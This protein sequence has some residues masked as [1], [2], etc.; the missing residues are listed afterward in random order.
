MN[1]YNPTVYIVDDDEA[2][3]DSLSMSLSIEGFTVQEHDCANSFLENYDNQPG[4]LVADI[5]MP[6]MNGLELQQE[7]IK[8]KIDIPIIFITGHGSIP[9][10]VKAMQSG[11]VNFMEKPFSK[12]NLIETI[13]Q[14]LEIDEECRESNKIKYE[15]NKRFDTLTAREKEI[16]EL[17][18]KERGS[19]SNREIA[20]LLGISKRTVEVHRSA[21]M[22]KMLARTRAELVELSR[23]CTTPKY[24]KPREARN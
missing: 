1:H 9:Q 12:S 17:L 2:V 4:C 13:Q 10:S 19:L 24:L 16:M 11:A 14:A 3:R 5:Q 22:A 18:I 20:E 7:L 21:V 6:N 23:A 8:Q 15:T